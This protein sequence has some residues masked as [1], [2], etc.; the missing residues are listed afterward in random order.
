MQ[1]ELERFLAHLPRS[2]RILDAGCGG[3]RDLLAMRSTGMIPT[4]LDF[5]PALAGLARDHSGC[6]VV[7]GDVREPP[8]AD[9]AFDG[10]WAAACLLHLEREDVPVALRALRR[11]LVKGGAFFASVKMGRGSERTADGRLFTYFDADE[12]RSLLIEA[13]FVSITL[14]LD[15]QNGPTQRTTSWIQSYAAA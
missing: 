4:G 15:V 9:G 11:L 13:G 8:F 5:S 10:V 2:S 7:V 1:P 14:T 6:E 3:G 12:W